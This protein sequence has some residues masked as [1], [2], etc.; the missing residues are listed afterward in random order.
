MWRDY[1]IISNLFGAFKNSNDRRFRKNIFVNPDDDVIRHAYA[2]FLDEHQDVRGPLVRLQLAVAGGN[3]AARR[4]WNKHETW[5]YWWSAMFESNQGNGYCML[6]RL[7]YRVGALPWPSWTVFP[8]L[9]WREPYSYEKTAHE[10]FDRIGAIYHPVMAVTP[11]WL[12]VIRSRHGVIDLVPESVSFIVREDDISDYFWYSY[13]TPASFNPMM[14]VRD[15]FGLHVDSKRAGFGWWYDRH[16]DV[17][18][19]RLYNEIADERAGRESVV[20]LETGE[21]VARLNKEV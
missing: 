12:V 7:R 8:R 15:K 9:G 11:D 17:N 16:S 6:T 21:V 5:N 10:Y 2:D 3:E 4:E 18:K 1:P 13:R 19:C 14:L 20:D